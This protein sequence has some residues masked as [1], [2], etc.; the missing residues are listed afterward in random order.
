MSLL[1]PRLGRQVA[2]GTWSP[3]GGRGCRG[4]ARDMRQEIRACPADRIDRCLRAGRLRDIRSQR[5]REVVSVV[6]QGSVVRLG[7]AA[8]GGVLLVGV[9]SAAFAESQVGEGS[10]VDVSVTIEDTD[11]GCWR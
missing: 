7:A 10:E 8:L 9:G 11:Q 4:A 3:A 5:R 1:C 6:K 2:G